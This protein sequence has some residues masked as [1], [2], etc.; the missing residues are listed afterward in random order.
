VY[1]NGRHAQTTDYSRECDPTLETEDAA[2]TDQLLRAAS[3]R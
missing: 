3:R 2:F 1:E